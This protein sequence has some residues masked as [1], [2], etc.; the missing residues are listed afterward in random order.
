MGGTL[1]EL[2]RRSREEKRQRQD[3]EHPRQPR[4][5]QDPRLVADDDHGPV[6]EV[7]GVRPEP[8]RARRGPREPAGNARGSRHFDAEQQERGPSGRHDSVPEGRTG[9]EKRAARDEKQDQ[10]DRR[11]RHPPCRLA[12]RVA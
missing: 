8:E 9:A 11:I 12:R 10:A 1:D 5:G 4:I 7:D 2:E 6:P 3:D